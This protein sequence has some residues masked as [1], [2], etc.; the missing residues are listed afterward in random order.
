M[1]VYIGRRKRSAYSL[2][3]LAPISIIWLLG[4]LNIQFHLMADWCS[5]ESNI[6]LEFSAP[7]SSALIGVGWLPCWA[8]KS[9]PSRWWIRIWRWTELKVTIDVT[10]IPRYLTWRQRAWNEPTDATIQKGETRE[11]GGAGGGGGSTLLVYRGSGS[12]VLL[13]YLD[14]SAARLIGVRHHLLHPWRIDRFKH[15]AK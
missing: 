15:R 5:L 10:Q 1:E 6:S 3:L 14:G 13:N 4:V 9:V 8:N 12:G 7:F 2:P 11:W